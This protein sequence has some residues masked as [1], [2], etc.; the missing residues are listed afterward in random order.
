MATGFH[1]RTSDVGIT[2]K[3]QLNCQ[4]RNTRETKTLRLKSFAVSL[5]EI[6]KAV[7]EEFSIPACVQTISYQSLPLSSNGSVLDL[8]KH[9]RNGDVLR[10]DYSCEADV[11]KIDEVVGWMKEVIIAVENEDVVSNGPHHHHHT[12][13]A[14]NALIQVGVWEKYDSLL[15]LEIFDWMTAKAYVNKIYFQECGGLDASVHLYNCI[16]ERE[17]DDMSQMHCYLEAF[18]SHGFA[19]FGETVYLRRVLVEH[20]ALGMAKRSLLRVKMHIEGDG[21]VVEEKVGDHNYADYPRYALSRIRENSLH[22]F[23]KY[24]CVW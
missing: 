24:V 4:S 21:V 1:G 19:N 18:C 11:K 12:R 23:C 5:Q 7:Q 10:V 8:C 15:A 9:V 17:W 6:K 16:L 3:L 20:G 14:V 13:G 2:F 22:T